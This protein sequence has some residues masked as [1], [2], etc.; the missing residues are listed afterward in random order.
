[1]IM[2]AHEHCCDCNM[3]LHWRACAIFCNDRARFSGYNQAFYCNHCA[4]KTSIILSILQ[5]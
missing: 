4:L 1:M 5:W 2:F 3:F